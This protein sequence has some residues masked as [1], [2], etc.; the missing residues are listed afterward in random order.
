VDKAITDE[1]LRLCGELARGRG[2]E[3]S[4]IAAAQR[5]LAE[6]ASGALARAT[7]DREQ[8]RD[9]KRAERRRKRAGHGASSVTEGDS[10][11][12]KSVTGHCDSGV[13]VTAMSRGPD[14]DGHA[15]ASVTPGRSPSVLDSVSAKIPDCSSSLQIPDRSE[16]EEEESRTREAESQGQDRDTS[17]GPDRDASRGQ[18]R[19]LIEH[20]EAGYRLR[21]KRDLGYPATRELLPKYV[22]P[23]VAAWLREAAA[24]RQVEPLA[25]ADVLL[26][27]FFASKAA[28][29]RDFALG[30]LGKNPLE[31]MRATTLTRSGLLE[32]RRETAEM[33]RNAE[34]RRE[35]AETHEEAVK[36]AEAV[37]RLLREQRKIDAELADTEPAARASA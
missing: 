26:D 29:A 31:F 11:A 1:A 14:R 2:R 16:I 18:E 22:L 4:V 27:G 30:W 7:L 5:L 37:E 13:T 9:R 6:L 34:R 21:F 3:P 28:R 8:A 20:L 12:D 23:K 10:H 25:L 17:R 32:R 24:H 36:A 35:T 19:D 33:L 15:A